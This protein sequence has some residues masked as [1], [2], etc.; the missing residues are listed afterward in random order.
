MNT[1]EPQDKEVDI[2]MFMNSDHARDKVSCRS[3]S[4]F[5][6]YL[7]TAL[8]QW[9]SKK[10][11]TVETSVFGAEFVAMQQGI[12]ALRGLR[13]KVRMMGVSISGHI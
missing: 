10:P 9:F 6:I 5:S 8:V 11:S 12:D 3:R 13:H 7:N 2:H 4:G 1:P